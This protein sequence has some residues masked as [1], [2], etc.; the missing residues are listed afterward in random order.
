VESLEIL[1]LVLAIIEAVCIGVFVSL[2]FNR[3]KKI[4]EL[5][6]KV[7]ELGNSKDLAGSSDI[8]DNKY[9]PMLVHELRA[10]LSVIR[11]AADLLLKETSTLNK[12]QIEMLLGQIKNSSTGLLDL[13]GDILD[14]AKMHSGI[15]E[16]K[17]A[18]GSL[19][20]LVNEIVS[21]TDPLIRV[22][23]IDLTIQDGE[24]L[25]EFEFDAER[26]KQVFNNL[27]SNAVKFTPEKGSIQIV[28]GREENFAK[29]Q[30]C[31]TGVGVPDKDKAKLFHKFVQAHN[32]A[33]SKQKGTGLGLVIAKGIVEAH[34][35]KIWVQ[36]NKPKGACF[37]FTLPMGGAEG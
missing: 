11:G 35:G 16:V 9:I 34:G 22:K 28:L 14:V 4:S 3:R 12:S 32:Q 7:A 10:P 13:V 19:Q 21:Y 26:V 31:D 33:N 5:E 20:R 6:V 36:D 37:V 24:D 30:V 18:K 1:L 17:K 23:E 15:F 25:P 29:V 8:D 27:L 2:F